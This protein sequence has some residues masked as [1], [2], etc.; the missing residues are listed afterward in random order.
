MSTF[1]NSK[2]WHPSVSQVFNLRIVERALVVTD[3]RN[4]FV[5][6]QI[7]AHWAAHA[8]SFG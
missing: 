6:L 3:L 5:C 1:V 8:Q 2:V 7:F 4:H